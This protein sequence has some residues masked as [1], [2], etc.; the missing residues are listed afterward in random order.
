MGIF[1]L[2]TRKPSFFWRCEIALAPSLGEPV[3]GFERLVDPV[4]MVRYAA[5]TWDWHHL[6]YDRDYAEGLGLAG[7]VVDGQMFGAFL[8]EHVLDHFGPT[9]RIEAMSFRFREMVFAGETVSV[10]G[11]VVALSQDADGARVAVEQSISVEDRVC[12]TATTMALLA[13]GP[14]G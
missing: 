4:R 1:W 12:V 9:T 11:S 3:R 6:H 14:D 10:T 7:P 13:A 2:R 5:A 8:A